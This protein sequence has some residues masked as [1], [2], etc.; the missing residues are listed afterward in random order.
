MM[1]K[2]TWKPVTISGVTGILMGAASTYGI[3]TVI[4]RDESVSGPDNAPIDYNNLSFKDAFAAARSE[5]G[6]GGV[7]L[8][9]GNWYNTYTVAEWNAKTYQEK[10]QFAEQVDNQIASVT[11]EQ[12]KEHTVNMELSQEND[13]R[14]V[15]ENNVEDEAREEMNIKPVNADATIE[16]DDVRVVGYGDVQLA[17]GRTITVEEL[18]VNGQRVAVI[19]VDQDGEADLAMSDLNHNYQA[20][21]GEIIDL[22]TGE[23]LS[24]TNEVDDTPDI[25]T[26]IDI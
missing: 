22:H 19:D 10:V 6:P 20:D 18:E 1:K 4:N 5:M 2:E 11:P 16:E 14:V 13:V 8:W 17:D 25:Y 9:H 21:E 24:F 3:Q 26:S 23:P 7:F 15:A 12:S